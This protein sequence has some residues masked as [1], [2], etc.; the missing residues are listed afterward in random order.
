LQSFE[1]VAR[2]QYLAVVAD[3][4][5][6]HTKPGGKPFAGGVALKTPFGTLVG[7]NIT[8]DPDAGIGAWTDDQFV[9]ALHDGRGRGGIRLF[10]AMPYPAYT[11]MTREDALAIRAY[12]QTIAPEPDKI[13]ANRLPF[14]LS[15][16]F[17]MA[18]WNALNF[19]PGRIEPDSSKSAEW[20]RGRYLVDALG[21]CGTCHTPK[22]LLGADNVSAYLQGGPLQ[23][24][25]APNITADSRKGVGGWSIDEIVRYLK[26]GVSPD[27]IAT[28]DMTEEIVH[29]SSKMTDSDLKTIAVYLKSLVTPK[30]SVP[31]SLAASDP[32]MVAGQ[33]IYKDNCAACHT[34]AGTG[35]PGL[36]AR[37]ARSNTVQSDDPTTLIRVVLMGSQGVSTADA[38]TSPAMPSFGWRLNDA[39]VASVLTYIRNTWGNAAALISTDQVNAI[40]AKLASS[41]N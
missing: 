2:G 21:H 6:C 26:T 4:A 37:L 7:P 22:T 3:C 15:I 32:R 12:L 16:R 33:A 40:K 38:P 1:T 23:G 39:Q 13:E 30:E 34:D 27:S 35:T 31:V 17:N 24:W 11:K 41:S 14:P 36:F 25:F 9:A 20:N 29:S 18:V 8:P 28:G 10:P 19:N 5:A